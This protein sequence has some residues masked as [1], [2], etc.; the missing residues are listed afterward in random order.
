MTID[1]TRAPEGAKTASAAAVSRGA[2]AVGRAGAAGA[3]GA[4]GAGGG[5]AGLLSALSAPDAQS[6]PLAADLPDAGA[7]AA[8]TP[9]ALADDEAPLLLLATDMQGLV[10]VAPTPVALATGSPVVAP[11]SSAE[12]SGLTALIGAQATH[13]SNPSAVS[14][15]TDPAASAVA[16]G[17]GAEA[18]GQ[19][20]LA[21]SQSAV[22]APYEPKDAVA[23]AAQASVLA[24]SDGRNAEPALAN[25]DVA[26]LLDHRR[27]SQS[28]A[29][30]QTQLAFRDARVQPA[31]AQALAAQ[32]ASSA[33][34][35]I[36]STDAL[37]AATD[38]RDARPGM[39]QIRTGLEGVAGGTV[40]DRLG[41][42]PTYEVAAA[43]AVV[44]EGQVA[45]T[46]SYWASQ[47]VQ[48][49]ELTLDG[50]GDEP[51]EVRISLEGDQAQIEFRSNQP[52]VRQ[53][54]ESASAQLKALLSG[55]GL[56]LAGMSVGTSH[57]G[58]S[59]GEGGQPKPSSRQAK[60]VALE[61]VRATATRAANPAV[62]QALDL[63]V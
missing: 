61:P 20:R 41:I 14:A 1:T 44:S 37:N 28:H 59:Q 39:G 11:A 2:S 22:Q 10:A 29:A 48:S 34:P 24:A 16:A 21:P 49:A 7:D 18:P 55:E 60:L 9:P 25:T 40:A 15:N 32:D 30:A 6:A 58:A 35:V 56:Q 33:A 31:S 5:F 36:L 13:L 47:G 4:A 43:T 38:R 45:E 12:A 26:T 17:E 46:V 3:P 63:Y 54:L 51:V 53:A 42:N 19:R 52:E 8:L 62:G 23:K 50:M 27:A 57:R